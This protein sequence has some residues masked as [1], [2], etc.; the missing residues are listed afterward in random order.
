MYKL[1]ES[2]ALIGDYLGKP[3]R[4]K[5]DGV[6]FDDQP[7]TF[8]LRFADPEELRD[9]ISED[10]TDEMQ[11]KPWCDLVPVAAVSVPE[12]MAGDFA[13]V[14]LDWRAVAEKPQI[15]FN[16]EEKEWNPIDWAAAGEQPSVLV[17]TRDNWGS[18]DGHWL[19]ADSL[20][21]LL[22]GTS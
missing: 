8:T 20:D 6:V 18:F 12:R 14:F 5:L 7:N 22:G 1:E 4:V 19:S 21:A 9:E 10:F 2:R 15:R 16:R 3:V 13:W 11:L 17:A